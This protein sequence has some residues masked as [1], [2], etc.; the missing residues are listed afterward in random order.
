VLEENIRQSRLSISGANFLLKKGEDPRH[1]FRELLVLVKKAVERRSVGNSLENTQQ[2]IS[3]MINFFSDPSFA[4]DNEGK[5]IAWNDSVEQLTSTPAKTVIEKGDNNYAEP[6]FGSK[7]KM[8]VNLVFDSDEEIKRQKYM[9]VSRIP[10]GLVIA[11]SRGIKKDGSDW[12][13]WMK[14]MPIYDNR[15]GFIA[16]VGTVRN[17]TATFGDIVMS[18]SLNE[19]SQLAD[20]AS[21]E[22]QKTAAGLFKKILGKSSS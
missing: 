1:Q 18:D 20:E 11:V 7:R 14:A 19:A 9:M 8:L 13:L 6:F 4:I 21:R 16:S 15:G 22:P 12:T 10:K 5:V 2:I 17:V 3:E